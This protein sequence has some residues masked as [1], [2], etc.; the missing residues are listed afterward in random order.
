MWLKYVKQPGGSDSSF[1]ETCC[2]YTRLDAATYHR[3]KFY[4]IW[5]V[6]IAF[7]RSFTVTIW[8]E[9]DG[10]RRSRFRIDF[11]FAAAALAKV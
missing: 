1:A 9:F 7:L 8:I 2:T 5:G 6:F 4:R 3:Y 11:R 10:S